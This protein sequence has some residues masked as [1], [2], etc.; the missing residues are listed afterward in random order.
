MQIREIMSTDVKVI[1]PD[2]TLTDAAATMKKGNFG[3]LPV[4]END[5]IVGTI[6]D[7]DIVVN[8]VAGGKDCRKASVR[9]SMS[10]GVHYCFEDQDIDEAAKLM[11]DKQIRRLPILNR[12][13]R[14]VGIISLG[15]FAVRSE[16]VEMAGKAL[17]EVS[18]HR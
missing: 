1:S 2:A 10:P 6:T 3:M 17:E 13:K 11:S 7:R 15:D 5:R 9:E 16:E 14:L 18:A 4:G 12:D 8:A